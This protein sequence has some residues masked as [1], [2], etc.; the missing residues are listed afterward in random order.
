[1]MIAAHARHALLQSSRQLYEKLIEQER[2][3][4]EWERCDCLFVFRHVRPMED[5]ESGNRI[6]E[7]FGVA[8]KRYDGEAVRELK[9]A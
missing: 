8:A 5:C 2:M 3:D 1:M 7:Q 6:M 4:C 9:P